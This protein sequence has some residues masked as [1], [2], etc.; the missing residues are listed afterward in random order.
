[1]ITVF[2]PRVVAVPTILDAKLCNYYLDVDT[3]EVVIE[4]ISEYLAR[5][6]SGHRS[7]GAQ[8]TILLPKIGYSPLGR[9]ALEDYEYALTNYDIR[10][11]TFVGGMEDSEFVQINVNTANSVMGDGYIGSEIQLLNDEDA[12][13]P[14]KYYGTD[15]NQLKGYH[16]FIPAH[17]PVTIA[18]ESAGIASIDENQVLTINPTQGGHN[19]VTIAVGSEARGSI[20]ANQVLT[21]NNQ[22]SNVGSGDGMDF[23]PGADVTL[24][25]PSTI[26]SSTVNEV[27]ATSHTHELGN[28]AIDD[29]ISGVPI[30]YGALYNWYTAT[31]T[32]KISSSDDWVVPEISHF[33]TLIS[34]IGGS[35]TG[36]TVLKESGTAHWDHANGTNNYNFNG[37]GAGFR[38]EGTGTS[39]FVALGSYSPM[40]TFTQYSSTHGY[41]YNLQD[42][43]P[44]IHG[45]FFVK[46]AAEA[47]RL[48]NPST[49]LTNGQTGVYIGN[50]GK[51]YPTICI[52]TQEWVSCN[53]NE[54]K[55]RNKDYIHG[56]ENGVYAPI[57]N[58]DWAALT[59]DGMCYYNDNEAYGGG[60]T[61]L[62]GTLAD[63]Q[64]QIDNIHPPVTIHASS[65]T[66]ATIDANQ[67]LTISLQTGLISDTAYDATSWDGVIDV[68]PSK[69]A[70]RDKI[71]SL[72]SGIPAAYVLPTAEPSVLGGIKI[73]DGLTMTNGV[74]SVTTNYLALT[75]TIDETYTSKAWYVPRVAD[76]ED[77]L[78]LTETVELQTIT[79]RLT[80]MSDFPSSYVGYGN[81]LLM[82]KSTEDGVQFSGTL[83][84]YA[85]NAT[86]LSGGLVPG[87]VYRTSDGTIKIVY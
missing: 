16:E 52:G 8:V 71:E 57:S 69:N 67:V 66:R 1:M 37:R 24:G 7:A 39:E 14:L 44:G 64:E 59:T 17:E 87:N 45:N 33:T 80:L 9:Y 63:L 49:L 31:D 13:G 41:H 50:D 22:T 2:D 62:T 35:S 86:A 26:S 58:V 15:A 10:Y 55:F 84:V 11:Y 5:V 75:D 36:S 73:G 53:L 60:E 48:I 70:V 47:I 25:L 79:A 82:V 38:G 42:L 3:S 65:A 12:P 51:V 83:E 21:L 43:F 72:I 29:V 19:P 61:L 76:T 27:T 85:D 81:C 6:I 54:T 34:Y 74:A 46:F 68:A 56:F 23:A 4:T 77:N 32:R 20:D 30:E 28:V 40:W 78:V 18:I